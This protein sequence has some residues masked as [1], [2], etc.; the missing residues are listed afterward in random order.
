[1]VRHE[2]EM[3]LARY[4]MHPDSLFFSISLVLFTISIH[5]HSIISSYT[6]LAPGD[7]CVVA[8]TSNQ[9]YVNIATKDTKYSC[10]VIKDPILNR[11]GKTVLHWTA[12]VL[13]G[14][15]MLSGFRNTNNSFNK[16][17]KS[18]F[19]TMSKIQ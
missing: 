2:S 4:F 12:P 5:C 1:M 15:K 11:V 9:F 16:S 18:A 19:S 8:I 14:L 7:G 10:L 3:R 6:P 17:N 13:K